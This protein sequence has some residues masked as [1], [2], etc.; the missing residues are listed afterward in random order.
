MKSVILKI[1]TENKK[2]KKLYEN[3]GHFNA[4]DV[5]IDLFCPMLIDVKPEINLMLDLDIKCEVIE[6]D[7]ANKNIRN[8]PY[9]LVPRSSICKTPLIMH[10]SIGIIDAGYRGKLKAP[11]YNL[12]NRTYTIED[13][14]RL[15]QIVLFSGQS[16]EKIE[17]HDS[18]STT[19]RGEGGFGS[20]GL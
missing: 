19:E 5:G 4:G 1:H 11:I 15:F 2:L 17:I 13:N 18:L 12:S 6:R 16:I 10:N 7:I 9:M 8:L 14:Q 20:T 3:H